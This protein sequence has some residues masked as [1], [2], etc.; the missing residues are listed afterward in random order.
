MYYL[1]HNKTAYIFSRA[2]SSKP[3][4]E[5][6]SPCRDLC[7]I[8]GEAEWE[9]NRTVLVAMKIGSELGASVS[10]I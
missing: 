4:E 8:D 5:A 9:D 3:A 2:Y 10:S 6:A 1:L 7:S